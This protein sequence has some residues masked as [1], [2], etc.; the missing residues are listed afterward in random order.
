MKEKTLTQHTKEWLE[1]EGFAV[2]LTEHWTT[3]G[4]KRKDLFTFGDLLAVRSDIAGCI[5]VQATSFSNMGERARKIRSAPHARTL[6]EAHNRIL[7]VGWKE[8]GSRLDPA[9][10]SMHPVFRFIRLEE[11][12]PAPQASRARKNRAETARHKAISTPPFPPVGPRIP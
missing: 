1:G 4:K 2:E 6:L 7:L 8:L 5:F 3:R 9:S 11:L 12:N 10:F